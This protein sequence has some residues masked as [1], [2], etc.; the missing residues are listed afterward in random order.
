MYCIFHGVM[1]YNPYCTAHNPDIVSNSGPTAT[2]SIVLEV[3]LE[4]G[5]SAV[6]LDP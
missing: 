4:K 1:E 6:S 3:P 5:T 2:V